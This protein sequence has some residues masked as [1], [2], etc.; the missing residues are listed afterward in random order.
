MIT[1]TFYYSENSEGSDKVKADLQELREKY[2]HQLVAIDINR[3]SAMRSAYAGR[4]PVVQVGPYRLEG[5]ISKER[6]QVALG[7]AIDRDSQLGKVDDKAYQDRLERGRTVT[8]GDRTSLWI[9]KNYIH[10]FNILMLVY[11]GLPF[12]APVL[13][14]NGAELPANVIY[15]FYSILCYQ[16]P[17]RSWFL[18][19]EQAFYPRELASIPGVITYETINNNPQIDVFSDRQFLGNDV[20]G[21]KVALCQRDIAMYLS[22]LIFGLGYALSGRR[23]RAIPWYLWVIIGLGPIALDG[24]SQLPSAIPGLP[25]WLP[26]RESTPLLRTITGTLFGVMTTWYLY[27]MIEETMKETRRLVTRKLATAEQLNLPAK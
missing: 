8:S 15:R 5:E 27:P 3:D 1:V 4:V 16:L 20:I 18:F 13:M 9:S 26:M 2:P 12:I 25:A 21:Y 6:L 11:V 23:I 10:V 7:A 19:G 22:M 17:F 14:K 24:F